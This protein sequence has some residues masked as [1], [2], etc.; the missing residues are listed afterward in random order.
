[1]KKLKF[2]LIMVISFNS[3]AQV[4]HS[5]YLEITQGTSYSFF[6]FVS[7]ESKLNIG[8]QISSNKGDFALYGKLGYVGYINTFISDVQ[9]PYRKKPFELNYPTIGLGF[10][11]RFFKANRKIAPFFAF[12]FQSGIITMKN[13]TSSIFIERDSYY[14]ANKY[15]INELSTYD[16]D[17]YYSTPFIGSTTF[18][19][20]WKVI[21]QFQINFALGYSATCIRAGHQINESHVLESRKGYKDYWYHGLLFNIGFNYSFLFNKTNNNHNVEKI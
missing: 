7:L 20:S 6:Q 9:V 11:Y 19:I 3:Q 10:N 2:I 8:W 1:M 12:D 18:G 16:Y 15:E 17:I 14:I 4:N 13:K 21:N 5:L